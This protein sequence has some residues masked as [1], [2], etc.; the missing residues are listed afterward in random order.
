MPKPTLI[1]EL[2]DVPIKLIDAFHEKTAVITEDGQLVM[3]GRTRD[4][5][6]CNGNG[7]V[8]KVNLTVPTVF[9]EKD[10][11]LFKQVSLGKDHVAAVT[12]DGRLLTLGNPDKGKLGH[13]SYVDDVVD[14]GKVGNYGRSMGVSTKTKLDFVDL[15]S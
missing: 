2:E 13:K 3:W 15:E 14:R 9:E 1:P 4:G 8:F 5:S 10:G 6:M 7:D 12:Q 11:L